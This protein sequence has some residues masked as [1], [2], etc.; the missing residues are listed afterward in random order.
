VATITLDDGK[1]N[2]LSAEMVRRLHD[3]LDRAEADRALVSLTGR[4]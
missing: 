4:E 3:A 2:A 1:R